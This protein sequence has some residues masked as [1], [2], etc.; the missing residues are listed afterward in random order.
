MGR[1]A[2]CLPVGSRPARSRTFASRAERRDPSRQARRVALRGAIRAPFAALAV[3]SLFFVAPAP[4]NAESED[5][6]KAAFLFNFVRYVEWPAGAFAGPESS[7]RICL[8]GGDGFETVLTEAVSGRMVGER[9][10]EVSAIGGLDRAGGC[11][12]LFFGEHAS[13]AGERV[14]AALGAM[15]VFTISDRAGFAEEGGI[16]NFMLVGQK[17]RFAINP[18]AAR[19]SGLRISSSLLRL[20]TLVGEGGT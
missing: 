7:I 8:I 3:A 17:I 9:T 10:V 15:P 19:R 12:L 4:A 13:A 14:A 5:E 6:V 11:H 2:T 1:R 18:D 16:A 20:A